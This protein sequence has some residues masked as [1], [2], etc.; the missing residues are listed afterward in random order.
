MSTIASSSQLLLAALWQHTMF[1]F[2]SVSFKHHLIGTRAIDRSCH[3]NKNG[4]LHR[5]QT[6][7]YSSS[8]HTCTQ[9]VQTLPTKSAAV[10]ASAGIYVPS[11]AR[12]LMN[13]IRF[14]HVLVLSVHNWSTPSPTNFKHPHQELVN[15]DASTQRASTTTLH[16]NCTVQKLWEFCTSTFALEIN[17]CAVE[18]TGICYMRGTSLGVCFNR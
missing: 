4:I 9:I 1:N 17:L 10:E 12:S 11:T 15:S 8:W 5:P 13:H 18:S 7:I 2:I 6:L 16:H 3:S 14:R